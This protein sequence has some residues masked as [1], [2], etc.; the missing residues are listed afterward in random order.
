[1][2]KFGETVRKLRMAQDKGLRETAGLISISP[3][4]LSRIERGK[5]SPPKPEI[6][7]KIAR[8]LAADPDVLFRLASTTDPVITDYIN[9]K[10]EL[11]E[12]IRLIVDF[13]LSSMQIKG[14]IEDV[15]N[16]RKI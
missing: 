8:V 10:P 6:I 2:M 4:Y 5:E 9:E 15:K 11:L 14:I 1:M 7:K 3:A 13:N 12:L 16:S